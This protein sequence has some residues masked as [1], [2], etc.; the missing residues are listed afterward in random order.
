MKDDPFRRSA[1]NNIAQSMR[2]L[3]NS[4]KSQGSGAGN[5][6]RRSMA[7]ESG[8]FGKLEE[9]P[10]RR[11]LEA[12]TNNLPVKFDLSAVKRTPSEAC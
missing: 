7:I 6:N 2:M 10:K 9:Q 8:T 5:N 11:F 1:T 12:A 4:S 3:D